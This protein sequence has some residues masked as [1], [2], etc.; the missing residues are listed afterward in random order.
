MNSPDITLY[1]LLDVQ[2]AFHASYSQ[3]LP[4]MALFL[5][6]SVPLSTFQGRSTAKKAD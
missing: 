5:Q 2:Q 6:S 1:Q 3:I 4:V